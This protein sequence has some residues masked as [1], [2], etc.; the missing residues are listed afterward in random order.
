VEIAGKPVAGGVEA[1]RNLLGLNSG[2]EVE[3][4]YE[5]GGKVQKTKVALAF[6]PTA[7]LGRAGIGGRGPGGGVLAGLGLTPN[8]DDGGGILIARVRDGSAAAKAGLKAN[9]RL[10][11]IAGKPVQGMQALASALGELKPGDTV[12]MTVRRDGKSEKVTV[13]IEAPDGAQ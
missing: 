5:R 11:E 4:A 7:V 9:D 12:E 13:K 2:E 3:L 1:M 8:F 6:D 10:M